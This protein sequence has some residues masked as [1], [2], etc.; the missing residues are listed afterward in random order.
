MDSRG[1]KGYNLKLSQ[2]RANSLRNYLINKGNIAPSRVSADGYG[3]YILNEC[4][5][6]VDCTESKHE[7][8][9]R[10]EFFFKR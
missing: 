10:G 2:R 8:N 1:S 3:E 7:V 5:D 6:G 9:R 4:V